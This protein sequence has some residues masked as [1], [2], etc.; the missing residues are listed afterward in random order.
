M[1][2]IAACSADTSPDSGAA[3]LGGAAAAAADGTGSG[4]GRAAAVA[5]GNGKDECAVGAAMA[6]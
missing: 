3:P 2:A 1:A 4:E 6:G 5:E